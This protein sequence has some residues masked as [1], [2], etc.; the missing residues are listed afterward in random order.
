VINFDVTQEHVIS[1]TLG[2]CAADSKLLSDFLLLAAGLRIAV[3]AMSSTD[4]YL[5][6]EYAG[7]GEVD[8]TSLL[9]LFQ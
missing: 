6:V 8:S 3:E 5:S 1:W 9:F 4:L 2:E 7:K